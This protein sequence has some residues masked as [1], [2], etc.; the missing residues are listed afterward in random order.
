MMLIEEGKIG[1]DDSNAKYFP[2]APKSWQTIKEKNL[3]SHT[4]GL[5]EY[6]SDERS[7][8]SGRFYRRMDFTKDQ[9]GEKIEALPIEFKPGDRWD[10]RNT[11]YVLLGAIIRKVTGIFYADF[12]QQ[13]IFKPLGMNATRL[14]SEADIIL[15]RSSS[16]ELVDD[17]IQNQAWVSPAF[18]STADGALY[19]NV[20]DLC[21]WDQA[22]YGTALLKQ[23]SLDQLWTVFP[24][25]DGQPNP[26]NYGFG[27]R[28]DAVNGHKLIEHGG[29]WQGFRSQISRYIDDSIT[30]VVLSN[31]GPSRPHPFAQIVA[32]LVNP[33]F[34]PPHL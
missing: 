5:A 18:N 24:L 19:F 4:S 31:L 2:N 14:I 12:L 8:P 7:G 23:S 17:K 27:W 26:D 32:G 15:N 21:K 20:L 30:V 10:Y 16:Y 34:E 29:S 3:H 22:L 25:N 28:I 9:L 13:R 6:E 11:N 33:A 1:L